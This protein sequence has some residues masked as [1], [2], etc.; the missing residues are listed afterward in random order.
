MI[1]PTTLVIACNKEKFQTKPQISIESI[2]TVVPV[3]GNLDAKLKFTQKSGKLSQGTFIAIRNRLN[4]RPLPPGNA[5]TDTLV[6]SIPSF[7]DKNQGEFNFTLDYNYLKESDQENDTII[8]K[9]A[10]IDRVGN[11]SVANVLILQTLSLGTTKS[12]FGAISNEM[13]YLSL[14]FFISD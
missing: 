9:L 13:V 7:P 14:F 3:A 11:K 6:S 4:Q 10:V 8:F 1:F 12:G 2:N 5:S